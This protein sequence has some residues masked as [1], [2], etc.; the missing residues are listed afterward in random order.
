MRAS[1]GDTRAGPRGRA[2]KRAL[3]VL[4]GLVVLEVGGRVW[5][6]RFA[7]EKS[8]TRYMPLADVPPTQRMYRGHH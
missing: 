6:T 8:Y 5:L 3:A 2:W 4:L 7:D 1:E